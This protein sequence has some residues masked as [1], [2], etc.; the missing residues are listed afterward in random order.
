M[1]GLMRADPVHETDSDQRPQTWGGK[2]YKMKLKGSPQPPKTE[3]GK[4]GPKALID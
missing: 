1:S 2:K 4:D 3:G